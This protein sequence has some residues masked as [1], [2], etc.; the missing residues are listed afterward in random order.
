MTVVHENDCI[1]STKS[2]GKKACSSA[3]HGEIKAD[4][5]IYQPNEYEQRNMQSDLL[6]TS[7][8][9]APFRPMKNNCKC[10]LCFI[11]SVFVTISGLVLL[12]ALDPIV[13]KVLANKLAIIEGRQGHEFWKN[14]PALIHRK[15]YIWHVAN[16]TDVQ[17]GATPELVEK[18]P[19]V[20]RE[21]WNRSNIFYSDDLETLSYIPI[22]TLYFDRNQSIGPDDEIVTVLNVPLMAM[23]HSIIHDFNEIQSAINIFLRFLETE[24]FVR[25][26][27]KQLMEGYTDALIETASIVK[28]GVLRDN[29]FGILQ[30]RNG[31]YYQ[32]FT[33]NTGYS[34]IDNVAKVITFNGMRTLN[35]WSTAQANMLNGTDASLFPP[36]LNKKEKVFSYNAD[37]CRS[38]YLS[39]L[40]ERKDG[41]VTLYDFHLNA[42]VFNTSR[43]EN[44]GF[45]GYGPCLGDGVL[46]ISTCYSG[47]WGF[48][49]SPHFFQADEK[50]RHDV[51]GMSPDSNK[52]EFIMSFDPITSVPFD[53][54]VRL[55]LSF[56]MPNM[57]KID[58]LKS[59]K[60]TLFPVVWFD[61]EARLTPDIHSEL[62]NVIV[63]LT[64]AG[65]VKYILPAIGVLFMAL[66]ST[67]IILQWRRFSRERVN[68]KVPLLNSGG[69]T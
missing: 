1:R 54:N 9:M 56:Y 29:M 3:H 37:M 62:T 35:F 19:Y 32:N 45:C 51:H 36:N 66:T 55:Q 24:L 42:D 30:A 39:F 2:L 64:A 43:E 69:E 53:V 34:D 38:Y 20:Y 58:L 44:R 52:H 16:P 12:F 47:V 41:P 33:I 27:V 4:G 11:T 10:S 7:L 40:R 68:S 23:A 22:T 14:P 28:P 50:F 21:Q 57:P 48:I 6:Y 8:E 31:S 15:M 59:V 26:T 13:K 60:P 5:A 49:S 67:Y 61:D 17:E 65:Y 25:V 18:G 63:G 46:N